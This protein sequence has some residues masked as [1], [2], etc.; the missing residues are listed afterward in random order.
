MTEW[1]V[2]YDCLK[3]AWEKGDYPTAKLLLKRFDTGSDSFDIS[4]V[5]DLFR[6]YDFFA[7]DTTCFEGRLKIFKRLAKHHIRSL[8]PDL[9]GAI[10]SCQVVEYLIQSNHKARATKVASISVTYE[11]SSFPRTCLYLSCALLTLYDVEI[12]V[13]LDP[14]NI[15]ANAMSYARHDPK[16]IAFLRQ[17]LAQRDMEEVHKKYAMK[18]RE[19]DQEEKREIEEI[20]KKLKE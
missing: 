20:Y 17:A 18:K 2:F 19:L 10:S 3:L 4:P 6:R 13:N 1:S 16:K 11:L 12:C 7:C 14:S 8:D 9:W 15:D 5:G